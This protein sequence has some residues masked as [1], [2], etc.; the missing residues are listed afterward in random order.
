MGTLIAIAILVI[1]TVWVY[2]DARQRG[3][4]AGS[5]F[6]WSLGTAALLIVFLPLWLLTRPRLPEERAGASVPRLCIH[7][8][9]YYDGNPS[10]CPNCGHSLASVAGNLCS[11]CGKPYDGNPAYCPN[12]G[13][14]LVPTP[15]RGGD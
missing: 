11:R 12:C 9:K 2:R 6:W 13:N 14:T 7:C 1:A 15:V 10:F 8:G 4:S 3:K 5:A